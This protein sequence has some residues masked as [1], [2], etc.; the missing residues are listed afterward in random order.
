MNTMR[1]RATSSLSL[2]SISG[3]L[4]PL[5]FAL[6]LSACAC[7]LCEPHSHP[8]PIVPQN[9]LNLHPRRA[10]SEITLLKVVALV[11][12]NTKP[13]HEHFLPFLQTKKVRNYYTMQIILINL[14]IS[15]VLR[16]FVLSCFKINYIKSAS[17]IAQHCLCT[18]CHVYFTA[19]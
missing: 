6:S 12:R 8:P 4:E 10:S 19:H 17:F 15:H 13:R 11:S 2:L 3:Q 7:V 5:I 16:R 9:R 14:F 1:E 18:T